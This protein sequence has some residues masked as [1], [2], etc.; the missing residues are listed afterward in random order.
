MTDHNDEPDLQPAGEPN[1]LADAWSARLA[2][3]SQDE[4]IAAWWTSDGRLLVCAL[5]KTKNHQP[6]YLEALAV[7]T[8]DLEFDQEGY[9][10]VTP[11][12]SDALERSC[13]QSAEY[14]SL[15]KKICVVNLFLGKLQPELQPLAALILSGQMKMPRPRK[16]RGSKF[17]HRDLLLVRGVG[18]TVKFGIPPTRND[19]SEP[20]SG[21]DLVAQAFKKAGRTDGPTYD[22][23]KHAWKGRA[24]LF[25]DLEDLDFANFRRSV[26]G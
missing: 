4:R 18:S 22:G 14:Y 7:A 13:S 20:S 26:E 21:C 24:Q 25:K 15:A 5:K 23:A 10:N 3:I 19:E 9:A 12:F 8:G 11:D 1:R 2:S 17:W 6:S 16:G